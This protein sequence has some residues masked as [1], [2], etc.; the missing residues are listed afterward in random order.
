MIIYNYK[1]LLLI[2]LLLIIWLISIV[3]NIVRK[4]LLLIYDVWDYVLTSWIHSLIVFALR[5]I[6]TVGWYQPKIWLIGSLYLSFT[7]R[8]CDLV[9]MIA[10]QM[11]LWLRRCALKHS[12]WSSY[13]SQILLLIS[14]WHLTLCLRNVSLKVAVSLRNIICLFSRICLLKCCWLD[15]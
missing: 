3:A 13:K 4:C 5:P 7:S 12:K 9:H 2:W 11:K 14:I 8:A 10:V 1:L 15:H 6:S